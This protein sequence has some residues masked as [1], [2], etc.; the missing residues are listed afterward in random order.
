MAEEEGWRK[1]LENM[2]LSEFIDV[3]K[4]NALDKVEMWSSMEDKHLKAMGFKIG[5]IIIWRKFYPEKIQVPS[6]IR[7]PSII[8]TPPGPKPAAPGTPTPGEILE[9]QEEGR[10]Q[11]DKKVADHPEV[12]G[13]KQPPISEMAGEGEG[14]AGHWEKTKAINPQEELQDKV[15]PLEDQIEPTPGNALEIWKSTLKDIGLFRFVDK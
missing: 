11:Q 5:H 12:S 8:N 15:V 10:P 14:E 3:F 13:E 9:N 2:N 1:K 6:M 4:D 7:K